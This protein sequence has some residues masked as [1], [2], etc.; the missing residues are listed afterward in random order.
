[1]SIEFQCPS[2]HGTVRTRDEAAGKKGKCPHCGGL[3][4]IPGGAGSRATAGTPVANAVPGTIEF[5]C[6]SCSQPIRVSASAAGKKG[7]C[8]RCAGIVEIP[9]D[10]AAL[11]GPGPAPAPT[12]PAAFGAITFSCPTCQQPISAP[13]T[14]AGQQ[15]QCPRCQA[16]VVIPGSVAA[17]P[18]GPYGNPMAGAMGHGVPQAGPY[19]AMPYASD[20]LTSGPFAS[21]PGASP[22]ASHWAD[23][24][25]G[26]FPAAADPMGGGG[27][28]GSYSGFTANPYAAPP[29]SFSSSPAGRKGGKPQL[30]VTL[31]AIFLIINSVLAAGYLVFSLYLVTVMPMPDPPPNL[32]GNVEAYKIGYQIGMFLIAIPILGNVLTVA[33]SIQM[34]RFKTWNW[35]LTG[36]IASTVPCS[37]WCSLLGVPLGIWAIVVLSRPDVK[38]HFR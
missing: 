9:A 11:A 38:K 14:S 8:P 15:G 36:A 23:P 16:L 30:M 17:M 28:L 1:M 27:S 21:M 24:S 29:P 13:G 18:G 26:G 32:R 19:N 12:A 31:P 37:C 33:T 7:K 5:R 10:T 22:V 34:I 3:V 35:A 20:S 6:G 2:C 4:A 25:L